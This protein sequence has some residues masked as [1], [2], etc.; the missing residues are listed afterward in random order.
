MTAEGA[1]VQNKKPEKNN[2]TIKHVRLRSNV[3]GIES[4]NDEVMVSAHCYK[5][6]ELLN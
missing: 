3:Q 4:E 5:Y 6:D 2:N 1:V